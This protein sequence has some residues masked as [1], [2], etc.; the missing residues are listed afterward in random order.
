MHQHTFHPNTNIKNISFS[1]L[2]KIIKIFQ[3]NLRWRFNMKV[4]RPIYWNN[5]GTYYY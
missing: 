4:M 3:N 1:N 2:D 5:Y